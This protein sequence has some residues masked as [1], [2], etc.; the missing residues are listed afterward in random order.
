[1]IEDKFG[2]YVREWIPLI[3]AYLAKQQKPIRGRVL[4]AALH[5]VDDVIVEVRGDTKED[6]HEKPWFAIVY[7]HVRKWYEDFYGDQLNQ[8]TD[9]LPGVVFINHTPFELRMAITVSEVVEEGVSSNMVFPVEVRPEDKLTDW[10]LSP[11]NTSMIPAEGHDKLDTEIRTIVLNTRTLNLGLMTAKLESPSLN[12]F[13]GSIVGHIR[14]AICLILSN[15]TEGQSV[16]I[17]EL[18]MAVEK[19]IKLFLEQRSIGYTKTHDV[20][21]LRDLAPSDFDSTSLDEYF[22]NM[23]SGSEAVKRRY[24]Q[25]DEM[26]SD[27]IFNFYMSSLAITSFYADSLDRTYGVKN[28]KFTFKKPPW[29]DLPSAPPSPQSTCESKLN[30][31]STLDL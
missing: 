25:G 27:Y 18:H 7:W 1:M 3:D 22:G 10:F 26:S 17:W 6:Y 12:E 20:R 31:N 19:S 5:F 2:D 16:S 14:T 8:P 23:I 13:A 29:L 21:K 28:A 24:C 30:Y 4:S 9:E 11:P 15:N